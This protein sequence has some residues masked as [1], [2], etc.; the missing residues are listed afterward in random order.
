MSIDRLSCYSIIYRPFQLGLLK[1]M[2]AITVEKPNKGAGMI[3]LTVLQ[4]AKIYGPRCIIVDLDTAR[5]ERAV[6]FGADETIHSTPGTVK[7]PLRKRMTV[8]D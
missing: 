4:V 3:G 8:L 2:V 1:I 7:R 5:L 6:K